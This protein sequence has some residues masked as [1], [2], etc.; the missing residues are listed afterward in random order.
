MPPMIHTSI[1][2][3]MSRRISAPRR[4]TNLAL[5]RWCS[6]NRWAVTEMKIW[7][8]GREGAGEMIAHATATYSIP[9]R[10]DSDSDADA[11]SDQKNV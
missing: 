7:S 1:D 11:D 9:D 2:S 10:R 4:P 5:A 3:M 8:E 6:G